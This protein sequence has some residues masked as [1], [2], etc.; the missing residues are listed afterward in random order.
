MITVYDERG[1]ELKIKRSDW[2]ASVL[3]PAI[4]KAWNDPKALSAQVVQALQDD[5]VEQV[6]QAVEHL[7]EID[8]ESQDALVIVALVRM[9]MGDLDGAEDALQRSITKHGPTGVALTNL[10]KV[11]ERRGDK[12]QSRATFRRALEL[13]P[14]QDNGLLWRAALAKEERG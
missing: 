14:N 1:R 11:L 10:A 7:V 3:A 9:E 5:L 4:E 8:H 13:D 2:V 12:A 6:G